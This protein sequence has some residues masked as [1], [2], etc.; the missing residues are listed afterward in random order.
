MTDAIAAAANAS[1]EPLSQTVLGHFGENIYRCYQ[2]NKCS[3]GCPL[4]DRFDLTPNQVMRSVQLN[5]ARVLESRAIWLC[6]SCQTCTTR[7][8]QQID[9]TGV[10]DSLRIEANQRGIPPAIPEIARFNSL[11]LRLVRLVGRVPELLLIL[12]YNL[13]QGQP[14]RDLRMGLRLIRRGRLKPFPHFARPPKHVKRLA[15]PKNK[16]GY[17]P[18][19]AS[20][21]SAAEYDRT[22][23]EAARLLDI[24][25]VEPPGWTCCG[26]SAAHATDKELAH[27][28]PMSTLS[29][30]E[31]MGLDTVTSPCSNCF[32]RLKA[33]EYTNRQNGSPRDESAEASSSVQVQHLVDTIMERVTPEEIARRVKQPLQNLKVACYYGCLITRPSQITG[34]EHAE[35]PMKM[36]RMIRALG[37]ETVEWSG[38]TDCCGGALSLTQTSLALEMSRKVI[39]NARDCGAEAIVT[40]CPLCHMNLDAR[41]ESLGLD[42]EIPILHATQLMVLAFGQGPKAALLD[43]NLVDPRPLF[44]SKQ[45]MAR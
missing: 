7:C 26:A 21:S 36:D 11:F 28:M 15:D 16:V 43:K 32:A 40:M 13:R 30:I 31:K 41:Q 20:L 10:M 6:A 22:A 8:P 2:C 33:A 35:Y 4:S 9:V 18:G 19:C 39:D 38:K 17:F 34:A 29:T 24:E 1:A 3:A 42:R 14:F 23:R 44:E 12:I 25:L 37:A 27:E 45:L 5:D